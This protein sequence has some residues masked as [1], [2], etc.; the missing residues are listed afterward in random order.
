MA[1]GTSGEGES[2]TTGMPT[3]STRSCP[4]GMG[5]VGAGEAAGRGRS[6]GQRRSRPWNSRRG[7][8]TSSGWTRG[9]AGPEAIIN[10]RWLGASGGGSSSA[11]PSGD[12]ARRRQGNRRCRVVWRRRRRGRISDLGGVGSLWGARRGRNMLG[13]T[14]RC[15]GGFC[16][17]RATPGE[18]GKNRSESSVGGRKIFS[19]A[20]TAIVGGDG[21]S[22]TSDESPR[23]SREV[24]SPHTWPVCAKVAK[25]RRGERE[26]TQSSARSGV[27]AHSK[28][29]R[30]S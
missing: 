17:A 2:L 15:S 5:T 12:A 29:R 27:P 28:Q 11:R 30:G 22:Y 21:G 16:R 1:D 26:S 14:R 24:V 20:G 3:G 4:D 8:S 18:Y 9:P 23:R 7:D 10:T 13:D 25:I 19:T 6:D